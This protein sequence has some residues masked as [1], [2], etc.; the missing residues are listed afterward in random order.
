MKVVSA[1]RQGP[2][3]RKRP[4]GAWEASGA[5]NWFG[6]RLIERAHNLAAILHHPLVRQL[7]LFPRSS[8][9]VQLWNHLPLDH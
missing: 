4:A 9:L 2:A 1:T 8:H 6:Y 3:E 5:S 7:V